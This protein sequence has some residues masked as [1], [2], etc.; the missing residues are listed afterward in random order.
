[1]IFDLRNLRR[2]L[3]KLSYFNDELFHT[4]IKIFS[5]K[6]IMLI[7]KNNGK[8]FQLKT[9]AVWSIDFTTA[10]YRL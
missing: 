6:I 9:F 5:D 8:E 2:A 3:E 7:F 10:K 1:M 4:S